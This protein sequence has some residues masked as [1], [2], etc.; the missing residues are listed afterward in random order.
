MK[1]PSQLVASVVI[2]LLTVLGLALLQFFSRR[3]LR[4][5]RASPRIAEARR[6]QLVTLVEV[7]R[8]AL[9]AL[10]VASAVLMLLGTF[11]V[12]ITPV[13]ASAGVAGLAVSLGAQS[14]IK[15]TIGGLLILLENQFAVGDCIVVGAVSGQVERLTLRA[16]YV[17]DVYG[18]LFVVPNGDVRVVANESR[19]WARAVVDVGVAYEEDVDRALG[20]LARTATAFAQDPTF[21]PYLLDAPQVLGPLSLGDWAV[22]MRVM[23]KTQPGKQP[24]VTRGLQKQILAA[25]E[26][27]GIALPYPRQEV[28]VHG[29]EQ[30]SA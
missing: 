25:C 2:V 29:S 1:L 27:A 16:T 6:Q 19:E 7:C 15:D 30:A 26:Q 13:L 28:W 14:L 3:I 10:I 24:E 4:L 20:V 17:R 9:D 23:V 18:R 21:A 5:V 12:N 22:T 11:G 8:W